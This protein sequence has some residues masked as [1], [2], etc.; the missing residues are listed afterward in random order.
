MLDCI[1]LRIT[2]ARRFRLF[3]RSCCGLIS[4]T[5]L[6]QASEDEASD[7]GLLTGV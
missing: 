6:C 2:W 1:S 3:L 5:P 7:A 4:T